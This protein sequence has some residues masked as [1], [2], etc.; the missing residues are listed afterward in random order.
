M[1][2]HQFLDTAVFVG[3]VFKH[4]CW[5]RA[6]C[7]CLSGSDKKY[8]SAR[9]TGEFTNKVGTIRR[10]SSGNLLEVMDKL[11][12]K[13]QSDFVSLMDLGWLVAVCNGMRIW[14]FIN[15]FAGKLKNENITFGELVRRLHTAHS[16]YMAETLIQEQLITKR[17]NPN[18]ILC[19]MRRLP[20]NS[21]YSQVS[22]VVDNSN[23]VKILLDAHDLASNRNIRP[24]E[25]VTGDKEHIKSNEATIVKC[26]KITKVRYLLEFMP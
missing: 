25:F 11:R 7:I 2:I 4:D 8:T 9:V 26:L 12:R 24:L 17:F 1:T 14:R 13:N 15:W 6:S 23:D 16:D 22:A 3:Y 21:L 5:G 20:Y 19:W 10:E 18:D